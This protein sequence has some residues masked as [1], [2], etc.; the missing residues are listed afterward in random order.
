MN[1]QT[2]EG[3]GFTPPVDPATSTETETFPAAEE[4]VPPTLS[5]NVSEDIPSEDKFGA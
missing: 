2:T 3:G 5:V 4:E 1:D